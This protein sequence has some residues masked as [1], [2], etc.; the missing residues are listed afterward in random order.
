MK[1]FTLIELLVVIAIIA[2]LASML[3]P[4]LN[5]AREKAHG[6]S[7]ANNLKQFQ[8]GFAQYLDSNNEF[9]PVWG[10]WGAVNR[11]AYVLQQS[12]IADKLF[13][14]SSNREAG[15]PIAYGMR[16]IWDSVSVNI[17]VKISRLKQPTKQTVAVDL[18]PATSLK[19]ASCFTNTNFFNYRHSEH[20]NCSFL[21]GHV[22]SFTKTAALTG[23]DVLWW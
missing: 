3:L 1:K 4:A 11:W 12:G 22:S 10:N 19:T 23:Q 5:K 2:I 16:G 20:I 15:K 9:V 21:D 17:G 18:N 6:I 14:C 7:C 8:L 13:E